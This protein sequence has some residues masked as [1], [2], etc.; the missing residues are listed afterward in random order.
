MCP[1]QEMSTPASL[2]GV[3][4]RRRAGTFGYVEQT[5]VRSSSQS[6]ITCAYRASWPCRMC[7][8]VANAE[9]RLALARGDISHRR[10]VKHVGEWGAEAAPAETLLAKIKAD[11]DAA[12]KLRIG[13]SCWHGQQPMR[14]LDRASGPVLDVYAERVLARVDA[15]PTTLRD[16]RLHYC[17]DLMIQEVSKAPLGIGA[18]WGS[19][20]ITA[21]TPH[22]VQQWLLE[23]QTRP[24]R[25][26]GVL[27]SASQVRQRFWLLRRILRVAMEDVALGVDPTEGIAP[28]PP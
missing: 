23:T 10:R 16:D 7:Q 5:V 22:E 20:P 15:A 18:R 11:N 8:A 2:R 9:H 13:V 4:G 17:E 26:T 14:A 1:L 19:T 6:E 24:S 12:K 27:L 25:R 28:P 3:A 21:I